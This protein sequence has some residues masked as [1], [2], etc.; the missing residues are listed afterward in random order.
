[1]KTANLMAISVLLLVAGGI[2][3]CAMF[4]KGA[5]AT[6]PLVFTDGSEA[7]IGDQIYKRPNGDATALPADPETGEKFE[8][9]MV[10]D[11][12]KI[13]QWINA[14]GTVGSSA[15]GVGWIIGLV[16]AGLGA[17]GV[18]ATMAANKKKLADAGAKPK[19]A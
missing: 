17:G 4:E 7:G 12:E 19:K 14:G 15:P 11:G 10:I 2:T 1:V 3:S 13:E 5:K 9:F 8:E 18:G 6:E 16:A